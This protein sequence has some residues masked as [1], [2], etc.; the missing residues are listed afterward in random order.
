M[1][2]QL[3][4]WLDEWWCSAT[5]A[6]LEPKVHVGHGIIQG[7]R[8]D[9]ARVVVPR[10]ITTDSVPCTNMGYGTPL[11]L[12]TTR[13]TRVAHRLT[14]TEK[15]RTKKTRLCGP[16]FATSFIDPGA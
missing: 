7:N 5:G 4:V 12:T 2:S 1:R 8:S 16:T 9:L 13:R 10:D 15:F 3:C 6:T 11:G 14:E